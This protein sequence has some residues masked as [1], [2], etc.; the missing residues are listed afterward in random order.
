MNEVRQDK[1]AEGHAVLFVLGEDQAVG[2]ATLAHTPQGVN[3]PYEYSISAGADR[4]LAL[5]LNRE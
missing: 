5:A 4:Q 3:V 2:I 1:E